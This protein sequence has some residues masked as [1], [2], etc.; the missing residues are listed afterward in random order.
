MDLKRNQK[1]WEVQQILHIK[2]DCHILMR[3]IEPLMVI[4]GT[5]KRLG[6]MSWNMNLMNY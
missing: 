5:N 3:Q 2:M 1:R 6:D 4:F